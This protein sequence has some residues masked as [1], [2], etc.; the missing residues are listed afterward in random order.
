MDL[1]NTLAPLFLLLRPRIQGF[2]NRL[3]R[4]PETRWKIILFVLLGAAFWGGI[5][6]AF[7]R[8]LNY[9]S[10][11]PGFGEVLSQKVLSMIL[12]TFFTLLI[13]SH[14]ITALANFFL[15][16]DLALIHETP[17]PRLI[18]FSA[19]YLES[20]FDASWMV[21]LLG[22]PIFFCYGIIFQA[23]VGFYLLL[24]LVFLPFVFLAGSLGISVTLLL[25][26]FFP[27]R[28]TRDLLV[29]L[30]LIL[31]GLLF[32]IF[33]LMRPEQLVN[34]EQLSSLA[35]YL[36]SLSA[37]DSPFLPSA[38]TK[39]IFWALLKGDFFSTLLPLGLLW[40]SAGLVFMSNL[41]LGRQFFFRSYS[42]AQEG[43]YKGL[44]I[45]ARFDVWLRRLLPSNPD[46]QSL[47]LKD[48]KTFY[49]D[50]TQW[51]QLFILLVLIVVYVYNFSVLPL[52]KSPLPTLYLKNVISFLNLGL[53]GFVLSS[54]AVRFVFPAISAEGQAFWMIRSS[55]MVLKTFLR[56][57]LVFYFIPLMVLAELLMVF[58]N[59]QLGV[60]GAMQWI[61]SLTMLSLTFGLVGLA[62][63]LG[64]L[65]PRYSAEN[66]G[67]MATGFGG[68]LYML[69][70]LALIGLTIVLEAGPVYRMLITDLR[71]TP[72]SL[73]DR[74][75][76]IGSFGAVFFMHISSGI[77]AMRKGRASLEKT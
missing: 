76:M 19:R 62:I 29:I 72:L 11:I 37:Q 54:V 17:M 24:P 7:Y 60:S 52:N 9:F 73:L 61:S 68:F 4:L 71:S 16:K 20:W 23:P 12:L 22:L 21:L 47:V 66:L 8:I 10:S 74:W 58:T 77:W 14:L 65:Y 3:Q 43:P 1:T 59:R 48:L 69:C 34:P 56:Y 75:W 36:N 2:R 38:W 67:Q 63:G 25:T 49:R 64:A 13:Y 26:A 53:A 70:S 31:V 30:S 27:I 6:Y 50:K 41:L 5:F 44:Q 18:L 39:E 15:S 57:K 42:Q 51:S 45:N 33:R 28:R 35:A 40:T 32:L 55:P 46:L